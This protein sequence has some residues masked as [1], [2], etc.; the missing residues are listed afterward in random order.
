MLVVSI[1]N[2]VVKAFSLFTKHGQSFFKC[3]ITVMHTGNERLKS[4]IASLP[5]SPLFQH[6]YD[7]TP[8]FVIRFD[9][10]I[11]LCKFV[12]TENLTFDKFQY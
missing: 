3:R 1:Q 10:T 11:V 2:T 7:I 9:M 4:N 8:Q 5:L 6:F 12:S